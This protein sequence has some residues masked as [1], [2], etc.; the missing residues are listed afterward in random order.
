[1]K[2]MISESIITIKGLTKDFP[3]GSGYFRAL[4]EVNL[5]FGRGEFAEI[6]R[7]HV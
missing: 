7:A 5:E 4:N 1:M 6:G 2:T 3:V